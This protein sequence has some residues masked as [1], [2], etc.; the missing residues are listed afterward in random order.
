[1]QGA[2]TKRLDKVQDPGHAPGGRGR[3][4]SVPLTLCLRSRADVPELRQGGAG[5]WMCLR[6]VVE[7]SPN[8]DGV[9]ASPNSFN[10]HPLSM[11]RWEVAR[12]MVAFVL[13]VALAG[14]GRLVQ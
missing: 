9:P 11:G 1:M 13:H 6:S 12:G 5:W 3:P 7:A 2:S 10:A 8:A 4:E 14:V